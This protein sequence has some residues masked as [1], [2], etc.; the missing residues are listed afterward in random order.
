M[1]ESYS[2]KAILSAT[3]RGFSSTLKSCSSTLDKI[4]SKIS[5]L[6]FGFLTG[7]GMAAFNKLTSG[8]SELI[9]EIDDSNASWK[10]FTSNME[11]LGKSGKEIDGVKKELQDFAQKTVYSSSDMATTFAQLEA[12]GT[13]NTTSLVKGFGGL[14]A[15]A[16]NPQ[17][18]MKTLSQ[19]ATQMAAKPNVAWQ[20]F[21]LM[22]EQTP[23][24]IAAVAKEMGMTTAQL[25]TKV[26]DG[27]VKTETFFDAI[28]KVGTN[29]AFTK[30]AT[31]AKTMGQAMDGAKETLANKLTPAYDALSKMGI[32][33]INKLSDKMSG[34]DASKIVNKVLAY[35][36][37]LKKYWEALK[38]S[39][40]GVGTSLKTAFN[41]VKSSLE[42]LVGSFGSTKNVEGFKGFMEG[43]ANAVKKV[44][45]FITKHSGKIAWLIANLPKIL[46]AIK[47]FSIVKSIGGFLAPFAMGIGKIAASVGGGL[48]E[49]LFGVKKGTESV[50][51]AS[52]SSGQSMLTAAKSFALMGVGVLAVAVGFALL[53]QSSIALAN[54]GGLAIGVMAGMVV[55]VAALGLGMALLLKF[56]APM[57]A[58]LMPVA[59]AM[60]A[61][62][63]A[64]IL[65]SA[66]FAILA[67]TSI[68]LANAGGLAIGVMVGLVAAVALLAVGAAVL[69]P[70]LTAGAVGLIA[71]GAAIVLV[72]VGA[73]L[74]AA[75]LAI[76]SAILPTIVTYG[77]Q[78]ATAILAL[79]GAMAVFAVGAAL[80]GAASVVLGAGLTVAAVGIA[81]AGVAALVAAA[82]LVA[83]AAGCTLL[84][85]SLL[86]TGAAL[87]LV[88]SVLPSVGS[89]A[90]TTTAGF[91]VLLAST[92]GLTASLT[93]LNV[94]LVLIG[95]SALVAGAGMLVF[96]AGMTTGAAGTLLMVAAL[97][98]VS[99]Q[100]KTI[101][102]TAKTTQAS[103]KSMQSSVKAVESGLNALGSKAKSALNT[104]KNAFDNSAKSA[105]SAGRKVG[106]GYA[107]AMQSGLN[108]ASN[109]VT[110]V[111]KNIVK[112]MNNAA[113]NAKAAGKNMGTGF[114]TGLQGGLNRAPSVAGSAI[115]AV[116]SR[117]RSGY[118]SAYS[119]GA[120]ISQ[121]FAAG[122][123]SCLGR[124]RSAASKMAE[125]AEEAIRAKAKI[126]SP[127]E[128]TTWL[129]EYWG[130][131]FVNGIVSMA[132]D[133]W[134][135]TQELV[136]IPNVAT[137]NLA[138]AYAGEMS[139]DYSYY[140]NSEYVIEVPLSVDGREFAR[141]T[142]TYTQ[143]ELNKQQ[144]RNNRKNGRV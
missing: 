79:G 61:M 95:A 99:S 46:I 12:V 68:A 69:A 123:E 18:A 139:G 6:S 31:E 45:E 103:L 39:F 137:P 85:A 51:E 49:K 67:A 114:T 63:A 100:M 132:R 66:G 136:S 35:V 83:L 50:G 41:A 109:K 30:L 72:G 98:A 11:M 115:S 116:T 19:Q 5:G 142:A 71:F 43:V 17:Q 36:A 82:G 8:A 57:G 29:D 141:A 87:A 124:I 16:E 44:A 105:E 59:T 24:G 119:C 2:V 74:A 97:K 113:K 111:T 27:S 122:M 23:A 73:V 131:G 56:L 62:G 108:N 104:L 48:A 52:A 93:L 101:S 13:K 118:G 15:A 7:A 84:G 138:Y 47:G 92:I 25:V 38:E 58:Q 4:D 10:T 120:Y 70:A 128:I 21:K 14:A 140:R 89:G 86:L 130:E 121:G 42:G 112:T 117:L 94:P 3:D 60:L 1:A 91:A 143:E 34:L 53:A 88:A 76:I 55:G 129:G 9:G 32:S 90:L 28:Q 22:L 26:Q 37:K 133:V 126:H 96:A 135:A 33:A 65:V 102:K 54:A 106:T 77:T 75:S 81:A 110:T 127:S 20:D 125:A 78:G 107:Q 40:S 144:T 80:A 134:R 64:V